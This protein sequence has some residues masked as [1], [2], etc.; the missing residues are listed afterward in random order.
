MI[1]GTADLYDRIGYQP[2]WVG[3]VAVVEGV[4]V[5]GG[6]FVSA[7]VDGEVE[8]AY[9]TLADQER[10]GYAGQTAA[11]LVS[12]ARAAQADIRVTAKTEPQHNASTRILTRLGFERGPDVEDHEI[13]L[14]WSWALT[15]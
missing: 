4:G 12:I 11:Q 13:G 14:A 8:I 6:A 15:S 7:P 2:P 9:Y 1:R 10:R 3:Y 5:G